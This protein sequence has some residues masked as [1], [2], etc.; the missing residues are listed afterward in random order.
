MN[1]QW[2]IPKNNPL[3]I[4]LEEKLKIEWKHSQVLYNRVCSWVGLSSNGGRVQHI[5]IWICT[6]HMLNIFLKTQLTKKAYNCIKIPQVVQFQVC[7]IHDSQ[8]M[9]SV[10]LQWNVNFLHKKNST[11]FPSNS[12]C[13]LCESI[14]G[15]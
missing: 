15:K 5:H 2:T 8:Y 7:S 4:H 3:K 6:L 12:N 1:I 9:Y 10:E 13:N 14:I 11:G